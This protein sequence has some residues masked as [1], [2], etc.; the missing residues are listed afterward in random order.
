MKKRG[1]L[2]GESFIVSLIRLAI[3]IRVGLPIYFRVFHVFRGSVESSLTTEYT[4]H[5]GIIGKKK[6]KE[7]ALFG[8]PLFF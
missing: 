6:K 2:D 5:T 4:E 7:A 8:R 3:C 1:C